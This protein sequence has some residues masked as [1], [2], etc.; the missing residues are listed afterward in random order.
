MEKGVREKP[1]KTCLVHNLL[2][3]VQSPGHKVKSNHTKKKNQVSS[4]FYLLLK[5]SVL[6]LLFLLSFF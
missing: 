4:D 5:P 2:A 1:G 3:L 6:L